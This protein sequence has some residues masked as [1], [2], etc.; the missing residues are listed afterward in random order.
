MDSVRMDPFY[1]EL[2]VS[3]AFYEVCLFTPDH[4]FSAVPFL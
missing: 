3:K 4:H 1:K 2:F